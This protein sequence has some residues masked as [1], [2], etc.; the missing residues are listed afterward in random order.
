MQRFRQ[1]RYWFSLELD[2]RSCSSDTN[3]GRRDRPRHG[4]S[5]EAAE[6]HLLVGSTVSDRQGYLDSGAIGV[7]TCLHF[8][9]AT[10]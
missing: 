4:L 10:I 6:S 1:L 3:I 9:Q 7:E 8:V 2:L 5:Y